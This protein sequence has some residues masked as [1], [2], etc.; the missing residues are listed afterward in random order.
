MTG[1]GMKTLS[2]TTFLKTNSEGCITFATDGGK[3]RT[4][5]SIIVVLLQLLRTLVSWRN[6]A[7]CHLSTGSREVVTAVMSRDRLSN[8][9]A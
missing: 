1:N 5:V 6:Q 8:M 2:P 7:L 4:I 3:L 9:V